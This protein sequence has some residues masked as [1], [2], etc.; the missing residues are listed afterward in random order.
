M[1]S[2]GELLRAMKIARDKGEISFHSDDVE[3]DRQKIYRVIKAE[4]E[5]G[6]T[7]RFHLRFHS[8]CFS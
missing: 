1:I 4:K 2:D 7:L 3:R 8:Q 6:T 5:A